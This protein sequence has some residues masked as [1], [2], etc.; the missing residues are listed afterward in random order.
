MLDP[1]LVHVV[2]VAKTGSFTAAA[3]QVGVTQ[4]AITKSVAALEAQMGY[5]IFY[6]T[7]RGVML[8]PEGRD[9]IERA[10]RLLEDARDLL[11]GNRERGDRFAGPLRIGVCPASLEWLLERPVGALLTKHP[12][13]RFEV[14]SSS[15]ERMLQQV[16][17]GGVDLAIGYDVAFAECS[18]LKREQFGALDGQMFVR[19]GHPLLERD[20]ITSTDLAEFD[21]VSPSDSRP[22]GSVIRGIYLEG[23]EWHERVHVVDYF[24]IARRIVATSNTIGVVSRAW[25]HTDAFQ[26]EFALLDQPNMFPPAHLC[27]AF[28]ARREP[29]PAGKALIS[30]LRQHNAFTT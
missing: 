24:P 11:R 15:F 10:S 7:S 5:P 19:K 22:Y 28:Q 2:S 21:F 26:S 30:A 27:C 9:F 6:R 23:A 13:I 4:S 29:S 1:R 16:R 18:D 12:S 3:A 20:S 14:S 17:N 8:T 25:S